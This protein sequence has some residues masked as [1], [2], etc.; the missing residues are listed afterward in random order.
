ML[1]LSDTGE[2][3]IRGGKL[4]NLFGV[5]LGVDAQLN[6][7]TTFGVSYQGQYNSDVSSSGVNATLKINF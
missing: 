5:G 7:S 4:D 6:K 2:A 3:K 1:F